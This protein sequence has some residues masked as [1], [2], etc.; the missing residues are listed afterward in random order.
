MASRSQI[1]A[2][3]ALSSDTLDED[4]RILD[5]KLQQLKLDYDQ[6]F[7]GSRPREPV[8]AR[9]EIQKQ[10]N[11]LQQTPMQNTALRF[12]FNS[13]CSRF[14]SYKR[15]WEQVLRQ[16]EAGTYQ[17]HVFKANL[18]DR[19]RAGAAERRQEAARNAASGGG[20]AGER[21]YAAYVEAARSCG[22]DVAAIDRKKLAAAVKKQESAIRERYGCERVK[23][24]VVVQQGKVKLKASPVK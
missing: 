20:S 7:L 3:A 13:I 15:Q 12:R 11:V 19:S 14:M 4:L 24:K 22:Q 6:Y 21:L 5:K 1:A 18:R 23:F 9:Q 16:I 8:M 17:R 2:R 10:V